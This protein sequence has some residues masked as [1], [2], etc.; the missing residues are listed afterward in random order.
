MLDGRTIRC[1][2]LPTVRRI[3]TVGQAPLRVEVDEE[4]FPATLSYS[5]AEIRCERRLTDPALAIKKRN[6]LHATPRER[7]SAGR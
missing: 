3:E 4:N 1:F 7:R 2:R 6:D 5:H